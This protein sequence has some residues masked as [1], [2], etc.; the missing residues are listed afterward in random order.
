MTLP[1]ICIKR[2]VFATVLSL[3]VL[4]IG[5][6]SY[7]RLSVR[8]YPKIDE[9]VVSIETVYKGASAEVV[10]SAITKPLE[11]SL[12]GIEGVDVMTSQSRAERSQIGHR[13]HENRPAFPT[14]QGVRAVAAPPCR[15]SL[16][17]G[18]QRQSQRLIGVCRYD[19]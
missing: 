11:D 4:L 16:Q 9:P 14:G 10:E 17:T 13:E 12:S 3:G 8:E 19:G 2:P 18:K 6:I 5:L 15:S 1:E 7:S